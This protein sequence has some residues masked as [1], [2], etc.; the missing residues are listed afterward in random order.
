MLEIPEILPQKI[1]QVLKSL[2]ITKQQ[3]RMVKKS[4]KNKK[5]R[6]YLL[7]HAPCSHL[8]A[9]SKNALKKLTPNKEKQSTH[10]T[11]H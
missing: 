5:K 1:K 9:V 6:N 4:V 10:N 2:L 3:L 8:V 7:I 11:F